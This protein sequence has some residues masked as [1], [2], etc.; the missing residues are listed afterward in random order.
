MLMQY[1][2]AICDDESLHIEKIRN[3]LPDQESEIF[4]DSQAL[5]NAV[6][7][8][9][10]YDVLFLDILMP[11]LDG[12]SLARE[13]REWDTEML[14]VF[15]TSQVEYMQTGYEVRA[16]RYLL[17][18]QIETGLP[19]IWKD[20]ERELLERQDAYFTYAFERKTYRVP[21]RDI[22]YLESE[23]RRIVIH[24][25]SSDTAFLYG[26][27]DDL[28]SAYPSFVRIHKSYLVNRR[29][30]RTISVGMVVLTNGDPLPVSRKYAFE[31]E[32][33]K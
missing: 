18:D 15:I 21:L 1:K 17:K 26:K 16:F 19:I 20:I 14:I 5:L 30:I 33:Y 25:T 9:K 8:G 24:T 23:L 11:K 12:I 6:V 28:A 31:L 4:T 29:H 3:A 32:K 13:L 2:I 10:R 7:G 22:L 27:L